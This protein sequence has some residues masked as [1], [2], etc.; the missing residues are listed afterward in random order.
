M[1]NLVTLC[2]SCHQ[3]HCTRCLK[4]AHL[5]VPLGDAALLHDVGSY[6]SFNN[7]EHHSYYIIRNG[8]LLGFTEREV[9]MMA[10]IALYHRKLLSANQARA[11]H[12]LDAATTHDVRIMANLLC[13]A[14]SLDRSQ[15]GM[16]RDARITRLTPGKAEMELYAANGCDLEL[17]GLDLHKND[18]KKTFRRTLN[19]TVH[20]MHTDPVQ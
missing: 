6:L 5:R 11:I 7:H 18:F 17:W 20:F 15:S 9:A 1:S 13:F 8:D 19:V 3:S 2:E 12:D 10:Y 4:P 16:I 14:N